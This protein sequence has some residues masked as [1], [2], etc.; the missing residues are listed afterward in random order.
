MD[1]CRKVETWDELGTAKDKADQS[2]AAF[3]KAD[4]EK[5]RLTLAQKCARDTAY[6]KA[7]KTMKKLDTTKFFLELA[8]EAFDQTTTARD[9][10]DAERRATRLLHSYFFDRTEEALCD[11]RDRAHAERDVLLA[12]RRERAAVC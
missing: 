7:C 2:K 1:E 3:D 5:G 9:K 10:A 8:Q 4:T 12:E 6:E 11:E